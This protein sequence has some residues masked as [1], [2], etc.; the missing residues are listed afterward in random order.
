MLAIELFKQYGFQPKQFDE[1]MAEI[2]KKKKLTKRVPVYL[3][4]LNLFDKLGVAF[5]VVI[6][7]ICTQLLIKSAF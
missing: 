5:L 6:T 2:K 4:E 3:H 1:L 7:T